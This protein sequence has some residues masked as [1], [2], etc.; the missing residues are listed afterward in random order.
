VAADH[1]I[2][3]GHALIEAKALVAHGEWLA[4][5]KEHCGF[6]ERTAQIYMRLAE[7]GVDPA[8]VAVLGLKAAEGTFA[9]IFT[10]DYNC[11][12]NCNK[13][14]EREWILFAC[15]IGGDWSHVEWLLQKQFVTPDEWLGPVGK[16]QR[17]FWGI[18]EFP[19]ACA[20]AW[21]RYRRRMRGTV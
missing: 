19:D 18:R 4:W 14:L 3:A 17:H 9:T 5:V 15:F 10:P 7:K 1:A 13:E 16:A 6:S 12:A 8:V 2:A 21:A 11:F 20:V